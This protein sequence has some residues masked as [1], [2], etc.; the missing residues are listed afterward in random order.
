MSMNTMVEQPKPATWTEMGKEAIAKL[1]DAVSTR[2]GRKAEAVKTLEAWNQERDELHKELQSIGKMSTPS[3]F[4]IT[5]LLTAAL[6]NG[7]DVMRATV[8]VFQEGLKHGEKLD[9][10]A[11][12]QITHRWLKE[13]ARTKK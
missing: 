4:R 2:A 3:F 8:G 13:H 5:D 11:W 10:E 1:K 9:E 6:K 7:E 12:A